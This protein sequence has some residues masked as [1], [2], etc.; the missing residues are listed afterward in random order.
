MPK[1]FE[2]TYIIGIDA[3]KRTGVS[4]WSPKKGELIKLETLNFWDTV[5]FVRKHGNPENTAIILES[6]GV[7]KPTFGRQK[8]KRRVL[9]RKAQNVGSVKR[10]T[11]LLGEGLERDGF[12]VKYVAP[13]KG[14]GKWTAKQL[15]Q[16]TGWTGRTSQHARDAARLVYN[17][18][19]R[20]VVPE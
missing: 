13:I 20:I 10:E 6:P 15:E 14:G 17:R 12:I 7:N 8:L 16:I 4:L 1:I 2:A 18:G 5:A 19:S 11:K 9:D 3:G